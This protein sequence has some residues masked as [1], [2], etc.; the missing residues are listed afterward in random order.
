MDALTGRSISTRIT[1]L[2][3]AEEGVKLTWSETRCAFAIVAPG[4]HRTSYGRGKGPES[5]GGRM[6]YEWSSRGVRHD[7][8]RI[9]MR[10]APAV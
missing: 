1:L 7:D 2:A 9:R 6:D 5:G 4:R 3:L 10:H 8:I